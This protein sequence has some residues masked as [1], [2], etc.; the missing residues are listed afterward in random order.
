MSVTKFPEPRAYVPPASEA[1]S[2]APAPPVTAAQREAEKELRYRLR[3][4]DQ[5]PTL[6]K[7]SRPGVNHR[8]HVV[9]FAP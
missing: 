5:A 4:P 6:G 3:Q 2:Y 8:R 9:P 1:H 7:R